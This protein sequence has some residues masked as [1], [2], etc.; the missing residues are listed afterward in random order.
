MSTIQKF[1]KDEDGA[2]LT[3]YLLLLGIIVAG[4][5]GA[6]TAFGTNLSSAFGKWG[7]YIGTLDSN[8][9]GG[10]T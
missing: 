1:M 3:E 10:T 5:A 2:A 8:V 6:S 7:T 4:V 9:P